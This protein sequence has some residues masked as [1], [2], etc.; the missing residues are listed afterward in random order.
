MKV[1]AHPKATSLKPQ[2]PSEVA[3]LSRLS[4]MLALIKF[5]RQV[6]YLKMAAKKIIEAHST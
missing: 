1:A 3:T 4:T 2:F 5:P 6:H